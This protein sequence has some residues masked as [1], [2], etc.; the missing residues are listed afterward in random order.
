MHRRKPE[1]HPKR[2][3][4]VE[5]YKHRTDP[6]PATRGFTMD[7]WGARVGAVKHLILGHAEM[8]VCI[9]RRTGREVWHRIRDGQNIIYHAAAEAEPAGQVVELSRRR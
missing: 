1:P 7:I 6:M 2:E 9:K 3:Y 5:Y 4:A 8:A